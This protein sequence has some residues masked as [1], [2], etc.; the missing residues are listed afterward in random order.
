MP[1]LAAAVGPTVGQVGRVCY[2]ACAGKLAW[3]I[4]RACCQECARV[5]L[6]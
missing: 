4:A 3:I 1:R 5:S 2:E 6:T